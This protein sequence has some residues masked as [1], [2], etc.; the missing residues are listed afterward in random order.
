MFK[1]VPVRHSINFNNQELTL[2]TGLLALQA[3]A[4]VVATIGETTVM[5]NVVVGK[6]SDTDYL[7][8]KSVV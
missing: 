2:E 6:V 8:R 7:D 1:S 3:T 5:A 4:S